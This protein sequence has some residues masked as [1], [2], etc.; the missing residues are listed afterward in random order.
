MKVTPTAITDVL[1]IEPDVFGDHRGFFMETYQRQRYMDHGIR[2]EFVQDNLSFSV[3]G[4]L[5]GLHFQI[6]RPQAKLVQVIEGVIYDVAVDLRPSSRSYRQWVGVSLSSENR[7]QL[8]IPE[9][10]AHGF[11]VTSKTAYFSY[12][13]SD[14]YLPEDEGGI[15]WT[16][17]DIGIDWP[18]DDPI[19]S[20]K[21][22]QLPMH[23]TLAASQLPGSEMAS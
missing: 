13:C 7:R 17:P 6:R 1:V 16:D 14:Y 8:Y 4:T 11:C 22:Q 3:Y 2:D 15:H 10:F 21:D 18:V 23:R 19:V 12:K 5:R 9:G 20:A